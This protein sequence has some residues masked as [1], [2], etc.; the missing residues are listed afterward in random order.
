MLSLLAAVKSEE[1]INAI[2]SGFMPSITD[3]NS[4]ASES[5]PYSNTQEIDDEIFGNY[6]TNL[7]TNTVTNIF[8][9]KTKTNLNKHCYE[10]F[11][12]KSCV[13]NLCRQSFVSI[14]NNCHDT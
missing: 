7:P 10:Y 13:T 12:Y 8:K 9:M 5:E 4:L 2:S 11:E 3:E 1:E 14:H 6:N